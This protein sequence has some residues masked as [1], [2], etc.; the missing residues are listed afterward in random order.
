[1]SV[2]YYIESTT[3]IPVQVD[4]VLI[5]TEWFTANSDARIVQKT[6]IGQTEVSTVFLGLDCNY[7]DGGPPILYET[8]V[9]G[10]PL[11]DEM[12]RYS[13]REAAEAGHKVM[14]RR[15]RAAQHEEL[16]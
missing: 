10:G 12:R 3:G 1:M 16:P 5:W 9:F 8:L 15:V 13:T 11:N 7:T 6:F 2:R 14:V 4:G